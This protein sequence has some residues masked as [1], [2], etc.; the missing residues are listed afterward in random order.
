MTIRAVLFDM[1]GVLLD[2]EPLHSQINNEIYRNLGIEVDAPLA[3]GFIGR[4]SSERWEAIIKHFHLSQ[5]VDELNDLQWR[6]LI[7]AL[8][9]SEIRPSKG[10][11]SLLAF[12]KEHNFRCSVASSSKAIFVEAVMDYLDIRSDMEGYTSGDEVKKAK[13]EPD[14][15]LLAADKLGVPPAECLVVEDSSA[16]VSAGKS[17]GMYVVGYDNP[18]SPGQDLSKADATVRNLSDISKILSKHNH[19]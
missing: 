13:P 9:V 2:S 3:R 11:K 14:I 4:S 1:D 7:D 17:A 8:Y 16:G 12:L 5:S 10:L 19:L 18:T 6:L 15:F